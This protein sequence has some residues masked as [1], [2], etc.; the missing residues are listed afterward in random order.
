MYNIFEKDIKPLIRSELEKNNKQI[1]K[2]DFVDKLVLRTG[3]KIKT[4]EEWL[5]LA[6]QVKLF[7]GI[8]GDVLIFRDYQDYDF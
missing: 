2:Q 7:K 3:F 5:D 6:I 1:N 8:K 4:C